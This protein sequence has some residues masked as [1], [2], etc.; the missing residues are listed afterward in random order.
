MCKRWTY[1][2]DK[3]SGLNVEL[4]IQT[5]NQVQTL[6]IVFRQRTRCNSLTYYLDK[7]PGTNVEPT[8]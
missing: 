2:L 7:E 5:K 1:Y 8:I 6:N 3:E 4:T